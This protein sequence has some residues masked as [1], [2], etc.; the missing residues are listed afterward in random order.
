MTNNL[1]PDYYA[2]S[3]SDLIEHWYDKWG[4]SADI[5]MVANVEKYLERYK[6][7]N[8]MEDLQKA[9]TYLDRLIAKQEVPL[10]EPKIGRDKIDDDSRNLTKIYGNGEEIYTGDKTGFPL[11][12]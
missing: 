7:K 10:G 3:G 5:I 1:K 6:E 11:P 2:T 9:K 4:K 8:G 12:K